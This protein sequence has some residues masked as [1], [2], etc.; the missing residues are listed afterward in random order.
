M[1]QDL[2]TGKTRLVSCGVGT[3]LNKPR[4]ERKTQ[5]RIVALFTDPARPG[6]PRA[7]ATIVRNERDRR[8]EQPLHRGRHAAGKPASTRLPLR[9]TSPPHLQKLLA[10]ADAT[11][12]T[13]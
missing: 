2:L 4:S 12:T 13:L 10:A 11:G 3:C 6:Q 1:M 8:R 7:T 5:N 9:R